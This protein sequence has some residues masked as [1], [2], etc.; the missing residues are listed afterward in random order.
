[1]N[2]ALLFGR[3]KKTRETFQKE[4]SLAVI[5]LC[6]QTVQKKR[7]R[8]SHKIK[9]KFVFLAKQEDI[10][11][12]RW[13]QE[14]YMPAKSHKAPPYTVN[15]VM[16]PP[17][18]GAG[19]GHQNIFRFI[20]YLAEQGHTCNI[21]L[22]SA[23]HFQPAKDAH[24]VF[25]KAYPNAK[26]TVQW[27]KG[28]MKP[29]DAVFATGWE[30]AYP[31]FND[32]GEAR[33]FYFVQDFEPYFYPIGSEYALAENTYHMNFHGITAGPWLAD[34][35][36]REYGMA[37]DYYNFGTDTNTYR[38]EN[39]KPRKQVFFYA[40]PVT[41][42]R[43]FELGIMALQLFHEQRPDYEIIL[44]GWD[45][46]DYSIPFPYKNLKTLSI[47]E[48]SPVYNRCAAGL[49]VSLTNM[50]LLPL[51]LLASGVIPVVTDGPN[52]TMV[53][54]NSYIKF[55][56]AS[57]D[58]LAQALIETVDRK[59]LPAYAAEAAASINELSWERSGQRFE[60]ILKEQLNG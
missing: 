37:C 21:Y 36:S 13:S 27:L 53:S 59:D 51:E 30:T 45:V 49:V 38:F 24:E 11:A 18:K 19:G 40:R 47:S 52:N 17:G 12:A 28:P 57:P 2:R 41:A 8:H 22:Y 56:H 16:S 42:R 1:M 35:L 6:L 50:S 43:G 32:P 26:V 55:A 60:T 5:I 20:A 25:K 3:I 39:T 54:N 33:K 44:A 58:G 31:V 10:L 29:A 4:G 7:K 14:P 34:K 48:L 15:W 9:S 23:Q 46:S